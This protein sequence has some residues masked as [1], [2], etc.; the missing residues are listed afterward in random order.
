[1]RRRRTKQRLA[2]C[3]CVCAKNPFYIGR[4]K[5]IE[6]FFGATEKA[7]AARVQCADQL[8]DSQF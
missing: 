6:H 8:I 5:R 2:V 1:M 3:V 7:V 4:R